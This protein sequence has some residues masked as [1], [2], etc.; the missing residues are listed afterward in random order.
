MRPSASSQLTQFLKMGLSAGVGGS[1]SSQEQ[2][3]SAWG[4]EVGG[5]KERSWVKQLL[6]IKVVPDY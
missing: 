1:L 6:V 3:G 2:T 4:G 5:G